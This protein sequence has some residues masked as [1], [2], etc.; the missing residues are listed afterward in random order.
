[1]NNLLIA[2]IVTLALLLPV[3]NC[4]GKTE[5]VSPT[6]EDTMNLQK[7]ADAFL[8]VYLKELSAIE[9]KQTTAY[10][11]A[12]NS[13]KK[14]DFDAYAAAELELKKLHSDSERF[15]KIEEFLTHKDQLKPLTQRA[16]TVAELSF[17]GNQ[18]SKEMLEKLVKTSTEIEQ[19]FNTFRGKMDGKQY[20][21][22]D[23]LEMLAGETDTQKRK[24]M[25][26]TLKQVGDAVGPKLTA[27]AKI[28]NEA[29]ASLGYKNYW[30][31][32]IRLQEH[33][34]DQ[35]IA[36]FAELEKLTDEPF[37]AMKA[38]LDA[39]LAKRFNVNV[40]DM[41]PW[42]Y[43]NPFFQA[44]PPSATVN[45]DEFYEDKKKED[46]IRLA[47]TFL[48][49]VGL[50]TESVI[51]NSD[52]YE[53]EG[54]DQHAFCTDINRNGDVRILVNIKPT[55]E[56]MDTSLH[57]LGHAVYSSGCDFTLPYNLRDAAHTFTTEAVAMLFGALAKTPAWMVHYAGA[58][59][60]RVDEVK[61]AILEQRRREQLIFA[62]W[63]MV[64]FNFER[65]LYDNPEQDLNTLWW[66]LVERF[67]FLKRP[68]GRNAADWA[69]KPHFTIAPVYYHN[70]MLGELFAAQL[71][72]TLVKLAKHD[73]PASTLKYNEHKAFGDFFKEKLFKPGATK[74]WPEFVEN[75]T[76]EGLTAKFF[77]AELK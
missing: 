64:M 8:E 19:V 17:K 30:E 54:K 31:M 12:A 73:G 14:E 18:L 20:S 6:K 32:S 49:D 65:A 23:L 67:Q 52:L 75:A 4:G 15:K 40:E 77:A 56:W 28:R 46:I 26:E 44:A 57:E 45:L 71:R 63:T 36:I 34:P 60:K 48:N 62:R 51:A 76:G 27:L 42:H 35:L 38:E 21:N 13:G 22:N 43:D 61:G 11:A 25:W 2:S 1:M 10:W 66:D 74:P 3:I 41:T 16:L 37:K 50:P 68:A 55:A 59:A 53:R 7:N 72:G 9:L 47:Q 39:E 33:N 24:K 69:A 70:Y 58:D 29:A 5:P